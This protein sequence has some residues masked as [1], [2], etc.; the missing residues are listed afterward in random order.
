MKILK[1]LTSIVLVDDDDD[2]NFFHKRLFKKMEIV[3]NVVIAKDGL[4]ALEYLLSDE[5]PPTPDTIF[6]DINMPRMDGW[7]F[8]AEY[9][10]LELRRKAKIILIMLTTSLNPADKEKAMKIQS[11]D[12]FKNKY[13]TRESIEEIVLKHFPDNFQKS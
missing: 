4:E 2:C 10:K 11:V 1:K 9:E 5:I 7:S 13:L 6:L 8:L 12:G 3:E